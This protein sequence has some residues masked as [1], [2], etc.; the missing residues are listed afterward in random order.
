MSVSVQK[1]KPCST[2]EIT[3]RGKIL[4]SKNQLSTILGGIVKNHHM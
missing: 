3:M 1:H 4:D 2:H